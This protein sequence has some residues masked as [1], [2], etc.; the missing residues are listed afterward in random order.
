[1]K[2]GLLAVLVLLCFAGCATVTGN[3]VSLSRCQEIRRGVTTKVEVLQMLGKP[4]AV[5]RIHPAEEILVYEQRK[6]RTQSNFFT[7]RCY[8]DTDRLT[9]YVT[10]TGV[11]RDYA[12]DSLSEEVACPKGGGAYVAP[13]RTNS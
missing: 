5:L 11:A 7:S 4:G 12:L 2:H 6:S 1:M 9:V 10:G 3:K 13:S 8:L